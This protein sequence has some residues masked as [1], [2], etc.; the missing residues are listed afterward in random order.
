ML[1]N[2]TLHYTSQTDTIAE[3]IRILAKIVNDICEKRYIGQVSDLALSRTQFN[4]LRAIGTIGAST[5]SQLAETMQLTKAAISKN[6]EVLVNLKLIGRVQLPG[7]R[8]VH[9]VVL[10]PEAQQIIARYDDIRSGRQY[11]ILSRFT[12]KEQVQFSGLL[13]KYIDECLD[14]CENELEVICLQCSGRMNNDC[15]IQKKNGDCHYHIK[16]KSFRQ[17]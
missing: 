3:Q 7:D 5:V 4:I 6:V 17:S 15:V 8:R 16:H 12:E 10:L 9:Q 1:T 13:G 14:E 2:Q 11:H